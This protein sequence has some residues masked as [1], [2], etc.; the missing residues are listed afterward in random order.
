MVNIPYGAAR[1]T[2]NEQVGFLEIDQYPPGG[3]CVAL[4]I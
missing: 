2:C 4:S 3:D 1:S